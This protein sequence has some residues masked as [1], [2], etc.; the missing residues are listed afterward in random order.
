M[1][2]LLF[3]YRLRNIAR[4]FHRKK[5]AKL[6]TAGLF[7]A[8]I[9][10]FMAGL[11][12]FFSAG[13]NYINSYPFFQDAVLLYSYELFFGL[14]AFLVLIS[15][16]ISLSFRLFR[17]G[18][19]NW[20]MSS[21]SYSSFL[22]YAFWQSSVQSLWPLVVI[23][24]PALLAIRNIFSL[25]WVGFLA[26]LASLVFMTLFLTAFVLALLLIIGRALMGADGRR[27]LAT[28]RNL[29]FI[30]LLVLLALS[31][32]G[33]EGS[34]S[35]DL[36]ELFGA[37][38]LEAEAVDI[39]A[40]EALFVYYP[41]HWTAMTLYNWQYGLVMSGIYSLFAGLGLFVAAF[42]IYRYARR[43]F[44]PLWQKLREGRLAAYTSKSRKR[45]GS[46]CWYFHHKP[47]R[48][49]MKKELLAAVRDNKTVLWF[50]FLSGIWFFQ[51]GLNAVLGEM[52][53]QHYPDDAGVATV[54]IALQFVTAVYFISAFTLRLVFPCFSS[55]KKTGW[56]LASA[57]INKTGIFWSKFVFYV[58]A[59][60]G[61][62]SLIS[63]MNWY[64]LSLSAAQGFYYPLLLVSA[65]FFVVVFGL[66]MGA[67]F[68]NFDTDDPG[69][70]S[71]TLP[72]LVFIAVSLAYGALGGW[73]LL[74][75]Q[76]PGAGIKLVIFEL[77]TLAAVAVFLVKSP[78]VLSRREF[79]KIKS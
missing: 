22:P 34:T 31:W 23:A 20:L 79:V 21:P 24:L 51:A 72:G 54:V 69:V 43:Y 55:E 28:F 6:I 41:S 75:A 8:V 9:F 25:P 1:I 65:L 71:T 17:G 56:I 63:Y 40:I 18:A 74:A 38:D 37:A 67:I 47:V 73:I 10:A 27:K 61:L 5:T 48:A 14:V 50:V 68:P 42:L 52:L 57:P 53:A 33:W 29:V 7:L 77:L 11:Y 19:D 35:K 12:L 39:G 16:F 44:L 15:S 3:S 4:F 36:I 62:G 45:R 32:L 58:P 59:L 70:L 26:V 66:C 2:R 60:V 76:E 64:F 78:P 30:A 13:F 46:R 49:L